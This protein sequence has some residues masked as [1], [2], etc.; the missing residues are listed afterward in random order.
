MGVDVL[1]DVHSHHFGAFAGRKRCTRILA[2]SVALPVF[3]LNAGYRFQP[4]GQ[5][6]LGE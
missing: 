3:R 2:C 1:L 5:D 4:K 6:H